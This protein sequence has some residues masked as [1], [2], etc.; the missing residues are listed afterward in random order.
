M[1]LH[2]VTWLCQNLEWSG[3]SQWPT[4]GR[5]G[6]QQEDTF[7]PLLVTKENLRVFLGSGNCWLCRQLETITLSERNLP[8][9][10]RR[11]VILWSIALGT[12]LRNNAGGYGKRRVQWASPTNQ[13]RIS[14]I[15]TRHNLLAEKMRILLLFLE[16]P[17]KF[18]L[19]SE[20]NLLPVRLP[21]YLAAM[22]WML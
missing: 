4:A 6:I 5:W 15:A 13:S 1:L 17:R 19:E 9:H 20:R 11:I 16:I 18:L 21:N 7:L 2:A 14:Y 3:N 12:L 22:T 8:I 10:L